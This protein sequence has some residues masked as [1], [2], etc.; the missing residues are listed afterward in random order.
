MTKRL[1]AISPVI[2][3]G[4][5]FCVVPS[6]FA[7]APPGPLPGGPPQ[8]APPESRPVHARP[9]VP[10][11]DTILGPWTLNSEESDD[12]RQKMQQARGNG[13]S[14][15]YGGGPRVGV[16]YPGHGGYGRGGGG[17]NPEERQKM[18]GLLRRPDSLGISMTGAEVD[19]IDNQNQKLALITDG[20]KLEKSKDTSTQQVAAK[21]EGKSLV[22]D[23]KD[24]RGDKMSRRFEL[25]QDGR[26]LYETIH[27]T[28]GRSQTAVVIRYVFDE[29]VGSPSGR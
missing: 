15:G 10:P 9:A 14:G 28:V 8:D 3:L 20:R 7:Q 4:L 12:P 24:P 17:E 27:M 1:A 22:T 2:F 11:R 18:E 16:G 26:Q 29:A 21:W 25:S 23:E 5:F 6:A 13:R 19:V